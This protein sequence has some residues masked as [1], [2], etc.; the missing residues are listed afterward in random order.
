MKSAVESFIE[1]SNLEFERYGVRCARAQA[2]TE[3]DV[4]SFERFC[5][6]NDVDLFI[7]RCPTEQIE[8]VQAFERSGALLMDCLVYYRRDL[9]KRPLANPD[10][11]DWI[12]PVESKDVQSVARVAATAFEG[13][14][15]HYHADRRLDREKSDAA[16]RDWAVRSCSD[17]RFADRVFAAWDGD[18]V[19]CFATLKALSADEVEA[20]L[21]GVAPQAQGR[22]IYDALI[23][24][25]LHWAS[26]IQAKS[27]VL[28][29]QISN[30]AVQKVWVRNGFEPMNSYF[31]LHQWHD[32][33]P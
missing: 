29:T 10:G 9:V 5:R 25:S 4:E 8:L 16:Y 14:Y 15:G 11:F 27:C 31:T 33:R 28:S 13:Y 23:K 6:E 22:G 18:E 21:F 7:V 17:E 30:L 1:L 3:S 19:V 2:A 32:G 12:R 24:K 20:V 26:E